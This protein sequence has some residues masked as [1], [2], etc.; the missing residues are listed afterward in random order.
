MLFPRVLLDK[1]D[2]K[3]RRGGSLF[4]EEALPPLP[5][6]KKNPGQ[7][8]EMRPRHRGVSPGPGTHY[9]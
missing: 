9:A 4:I 6:S 7:K 5:L 1:G 3:M 8:G 2:L